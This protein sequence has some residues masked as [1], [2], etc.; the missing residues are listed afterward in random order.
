LAQE[1]LGNP[2]VDVQPNVVAKTGPIVDE[3]RKMRALLAKVSE[4]LANG[5]IRLRPH[6]ESGH[7]PMEDVDTEKWD[8]LHRVLDR[9]NRDGVLD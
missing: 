1:T 7:D 8:K 5:N 9:A 6:V 4:H 2:K 3:L